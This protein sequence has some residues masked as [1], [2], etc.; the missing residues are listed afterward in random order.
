MLPVGVPVG[1][2]QPGPQTGTKSDYQAAAQ[3]Q[4]GDN[5][6]KG[7]EKGEGKES[8]TPGVHID[9]H[10]S[11]Q[12]GFSV[13][14]GIGFNYG[15]GVGIGA[16]VKVGAGLSASGSI[17]AG[18]GCSLDTI[19]NGFHPSPRK[20]TSRFVF[21]LP[22]TRIWLGMTQLEAP[23]NTNL[24]ACI[25]PVRK[26]AAM[27]Q[28]MQMQDD[29]HKLKKMMDSV[30]EKIESH[31]AGKAYDA[32]D[33]YADKDRIVEMLNRLSSRELKQTINNT[34]AER[35]SIY[36]RAGASLKGVL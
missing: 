12:R 14:A 15:A 31:S 26:R 16:G 17:F 21:E 30:F 29:I 4:Q 36:R 24:D 35:Q 3:P 2:R 20:A 23:I 1:Q 11:F 25:F 27:E 18:A 32:T 13:S 9:K 33:A 6:S 19:G 34:E 5:Y 22:F 7:N 10:V 28:I 8:K